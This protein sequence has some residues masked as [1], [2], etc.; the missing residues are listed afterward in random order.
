MREQTE[1]ESTHLLGDMFS[2]VLRGMDRGEW[3]ADAG[4]A[5]LGGV[6]LEVEVVTMGGAEAAKCARL[7]RP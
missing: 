4:P 2:S 1:F 3:S 7:A 6:V 5:R